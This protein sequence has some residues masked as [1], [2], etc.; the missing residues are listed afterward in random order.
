MARS[1]GVARSWICA[2]LARYATKG[3]AAFEPRSRR[4]R[5]SPAA[6]SPDTATLIVALRKDLG[7]QGLDAGSHTIAWH[8]A[9]HHKVTVSA[10]TINRYL[11]RAG[12]VI[13]QPGKRPR[14][15]YLRFE[16]AVPNECWRSE[17]PGTYMPAVTGELILGVLR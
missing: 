16:A 17:S 11:T 10:S 8:L 15:S 2:L 13:P 5:T 9:C 4:P 7:G 3:G 6:I 12:L 1:Y 14:S